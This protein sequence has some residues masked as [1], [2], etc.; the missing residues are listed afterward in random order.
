MFLIFRK[1]KGTRRMNMEDKDEKGEFDTK[2]K[3]IASESRTTNKTQNSK[4]KFATD[5][6]VKSKE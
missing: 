6:S 3:T 1:A 4:E 2:H 5:K